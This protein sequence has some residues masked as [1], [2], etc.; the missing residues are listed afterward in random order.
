VRDKELK[1]EEVAQTSWSPRANFVEQ[2]ATVSREKEV[3]RTPLH[4]FSE[5]R[6]LG[7]GGFR[8]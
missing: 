3:E 7:R 8:V 2:D 5:K 4:F 6:G 1:L